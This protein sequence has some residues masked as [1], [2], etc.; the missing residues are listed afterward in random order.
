MPWSGGPALTG[1]DCRIFR[2]LLRWRAAWTGKPYGMTRPSP[3]APSHRPWFSTSA[4]EI[5]SIPGW[6][7]TDDCSHFALVLS[8][9][10]FLGIRG[11]SEIGT[12]H[13]RSACALA[14]F[15]RP[16]E[17]VL[18]CDVFDTT[19]DQYNDPAT[20]DQVRTNLEQVVPGLRRDEIEIFVGRSES[21][22]FQPGQR[23]RFVHVDGG[24]SR[25]VA[26]RDIKIADQHLA[27][28][29]VIV[30][31]DYHLSMFPEVTEA[32]DAFIAERPDY[33]II[34]DLNRHGA[35]GR[36]IYLGRTT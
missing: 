19:D 30:I 33:N 7:T 11:D 16:G 25:A 20:P 12:Y 1:R 10:S 2:M 21:I 9:Q 17:R 14:Y 5:R 3:M 15:K 24:H 31:D 34:A 36:K 27:R 28:G 23:F 35:V 6:F 4:K 22:A 29:G 32:V 8:M 18:L 13:G 26:L